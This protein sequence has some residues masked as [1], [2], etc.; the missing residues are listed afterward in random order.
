MVSLCIDTGLCL[1]G[2][3]EVAANSLVQLIGSGE[4][5]GMLTC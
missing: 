4:D 3:L 2:V 5:C 1:A